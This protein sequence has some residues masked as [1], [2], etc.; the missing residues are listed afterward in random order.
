M[1]FIEENLQNVQQKI[2]SACGKAGRSSN[3]QIVAVTKYV[4]LETTRR[5][6]EAGIHHIGESRSQDALPKWEALGP[7]AAWHFIGHLQTNKV[8]DIIGK[9]EYVHSLDRYSL[10][11][12]ISKRGLAANAIT[13]CFIQVNISGE[14]TKHGLE[15][16]EVEN[17]IRKIKDLPSIEI[18]GLMTMAPYVEDPEET[19]PVFLGLRELRD[20]LCAVFPDLHL[21][22]L[23]MGMSNDYH[24]AVEEGATFIRL[25]STLVG[26]ER[27]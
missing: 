6:L 5:A 23:S 21:P 27:N 10:A 19:R 15:P 24:I 9:F 7:Q 4:S 16:D 13:K 20:E 12:E 11:A 14:E 26:D 18:I 8:R 2:H 17:F 1:S 3:V 25:G 22:H